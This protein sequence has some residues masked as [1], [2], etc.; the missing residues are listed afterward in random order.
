MKTLVNRFC[1]KCGTA[2]APGTLQGLCPNCLS[3]VAFAADAS[4]GATVAASASSEPGAA[5]TT[6]PSGARP[7]L[8]PNLRYFGDYELLEEIAVASR[9]LKIIFTA[10]MRLRLTWRALKTTPMPPRAISSSNS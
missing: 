6:I 1:P 7:L 5:P 9:P 10:T 3:L 2:I 8:T 4:A